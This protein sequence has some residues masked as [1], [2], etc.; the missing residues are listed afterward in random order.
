MKK[1]AIIGASYL[2]LPLVFKAKAMGLQVVCFAWE[3][4]AIC[5]SHVDKFY[6]ISIIE[7]DK[8]LEICKQEQINGICTIASDV[9]APIVSYI[10]EKMGLTAN[11]YASA[12]GA[13]NKFL[14]RETLSSHNILCPQ[15]FMIAAFEEISAFKSDL[16]WPLIVKPVDRSGSLGVKKVN[17]YIE[18]SSAVKEALDFSFVHQVIIEEF[19]VG[20]EI[21]VEFISYQNQHFPLMITDKVTTDPPYFVELEHHQPAEFS[22]EMFQ[23]IYNITEKA[24][25]ALQ[26]TFGA[27][28]SEFKIDQNEN[29]YVIEIGGRM[30]GDFIGSDLVQLST[31]YDFLKGVIEVSL[32][33]FTKPILSSHNSSGVIFNYGQQPEK[34]ISR[35]NQFLKEGYIIQ[36]ENITNESFK[37]EC[38]SD[39][40]GY[41]IYQKKRSI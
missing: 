11:S 37:L 6:P 32:D 28:H 30:G 15:Y 33:L 7:K 3:K 5:K 18:L 35:Y 9:A 24:L 38:S 13:N 14:M 26:L 39:R 36:S 23:K 34:F 4:G 25:N 41:F 22:S 40:K 1:I 2:Q 21:S 27:S 16:R 12:L 19:I 8:I 17:N 29:I 31:G 20:R 10:A